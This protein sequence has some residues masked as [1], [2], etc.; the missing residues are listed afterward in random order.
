MAYLCVF[1]HTHTHTHTHTQR[2][3]SHKKNEILPFAI[4][5][6]DLEDIM[7]SEIS[8]TEKDKHCMIIS[9]ICGIR[10]T[11]QMN[12]PQGYI[13]P[14]GEYMQYFIVTIN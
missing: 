2:D 8:Q 14:H 3:I 7:L 10:K 9:L 12:K 4:T 1:I 6:I 11:K 5:W 13:V